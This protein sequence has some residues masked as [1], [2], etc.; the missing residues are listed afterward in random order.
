MRHSTLEMGTR[1]YIHLDLE[2]LAEGLELLP[3]V[4]GSKT[5]CSARSDAPR[6]IPTLGPIGA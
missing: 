6:A 4:E 5:S 2:S 3:P 1:Y